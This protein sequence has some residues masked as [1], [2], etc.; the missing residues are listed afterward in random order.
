MKKILFFGVVFGLF[1]QPL[2]AHFDVAKRTFNN[3]NWIVF[4]GLGHIFEGEHEC[5]MHHFAGDTAGEDGPHLLFN[6]DKRA[7]LKA[8]LPKAWD[9]SYPN[10]W[11]GGGFREEGEPFSA[12]TLTVRFDIKDELVLNIETRPL[13]FNQMNVSIVP[14]ERAPDLLSA[15]ARSSELA[16]TL[17]ERPTVVYDLDG[18][19]EAYGKLVQWCGA[20]GDGVLFQ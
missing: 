18:F 3:D 15:F 20:E 9:R 11:I 13:D 19:R 14:E 8:F 12:Q 6:V 1:G 7:G 17:E 16:L 2:F 4:A 5:A 10:I